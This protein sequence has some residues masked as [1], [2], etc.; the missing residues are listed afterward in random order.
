MTP[1]QQN[2]WLQRAG[3]FVVICGAGGMA[4]YLF[5]PSPIKALPGFVPIAMGVFLYLSGRR[6]QAAE[7]QP[8]KRPPTR[9]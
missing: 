4:L 5:G 6:A 8:P 3:L 2:V 1:H 7:P 9:A